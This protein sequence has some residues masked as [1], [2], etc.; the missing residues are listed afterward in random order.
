MIK[1]GV[2]GNV[3]LSYKVHFTNDVSNITFPLSPPLNKC[4]LLMARRASD[5]IF[6]FRETDL[7]SVESKEV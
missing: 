2:F 5:H 3:N 4:L 7:R 6:F 1:M